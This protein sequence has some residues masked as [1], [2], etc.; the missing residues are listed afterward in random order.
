MAA[1]DEPAEDVIDNVCSLTGLT[2]AQA[3]SRLKVSQSVCP[4]PSPPP[5]NNH[6]PWQT[7][8]SPNADRLA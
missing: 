6:M 4:G 8:Q 2:R 5:L 3:V 7:A 1:S